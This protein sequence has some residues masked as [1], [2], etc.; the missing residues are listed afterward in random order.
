[1][2]RRW[3]VIGL[4]GLVMCSML[5]PAYAEVSSL[6]VNRTF[7]G[8][9]STIYFTGT[10]DAGD[11]GKIV[12]LAIHD[13]TGKFISPLQSA[14]T[15]ANGTFQVTIT[16]N[17]QYS[18]KGSYNATAFIAQESAGKVVS[19]IFSPDGSPIAPNAPTSLTASSKSSSEIDLRW[20]APT[21][22]VVQ[23]YQDIKLN[24]MM[25]LVLTQFIMHNLLPTKT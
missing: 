8:P 19:F 16:T 17:Q 12:N 23:S 2:D 21:I 15:S 5:I 13:P 1:M 25:E 11:A 24:A 6:K 18:V 4:L 14:F 20:I 10:V 22:N 7:F 3:Y 9:G